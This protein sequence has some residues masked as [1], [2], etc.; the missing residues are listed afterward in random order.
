MLNVR[1]T[2]SKEQLDNCCFQ[3][4]SARISWRWGSSK[5]LQRSRVRNEFTTGQEHVD[6]DTA[7]GSA[8]GMFEHRPHL[9]SMFKH[10]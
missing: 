4:I 3:P 9:A 2:V 1:F 7:F 8:R 10:R 6:K 5:G